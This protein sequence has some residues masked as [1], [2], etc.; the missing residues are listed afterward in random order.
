MLTVFDCVLTALFDQCWHARG[1]QV[2][3]R[4]IRKCSA[5]PSPSRA[6]LSLSYH[7]CDWLT[8]GLVV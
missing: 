2:A 6:T 5:E 1:Q 7:C 8:D 3:S 4:S